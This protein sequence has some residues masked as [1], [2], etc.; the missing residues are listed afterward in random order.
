MNT[1]FNGF[2]RI[3]IAGTQYTEDVVIENGAVH[4]RDK[5]R[6]RALKGQYGHTPL[7]EKEDLPLDCSTLIVGTGVQGRLPLTDG[8]YALAR[9]AGV[10][11]IAVPTEEACRLVSQADLSTTNAI[12]HLTC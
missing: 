4:A 2:G 10:E 7:S 9:N 5:H 12:L 3:T 6:S 8:V 11:L 1:Q